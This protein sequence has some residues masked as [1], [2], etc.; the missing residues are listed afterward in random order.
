[1]EKSKKNLLATI[2]IATVF[3]IAGGIGT[4]YVFNQK[5]GQIEAL[6]LQ[7]SDL[8][9]K[10]QQ[11]DSVLNDAEGTFN[12][13]ESNLKFI[14]EKRNEIALTQNEGGKNR[15]QT[16]IDDI[17]LMNTMLEASN[18]KIAELEGRLRRSGINAKVF[19]KRIAELN[20]SI[21]NQNVEIA[22]LKKVIEEKNINLADLNTKV[23]DMNNLVVQKSDTINYKQKQIVD[24]TNE[25]NTAHFA[26]GTYKELKKEGILVKE[27]GVLG[28]GASKSI[29]GNFNNKY[30]TALDIRTTKTIPLNSKKV[31]VISEH[32]DSSYTLVKKD[33]QIAYLQI[34]NPEEFWKISK[35]AVIELK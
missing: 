29:Q 33:G 4:M 30:F 34:D 19:E 11:K 21:E 27:G 24:K 12:E 3:V 2:I 22:Q 16:V 15:K 6:T 13:I 23:Q 10:M 26:L 28:V 31:K 9:L 32:P 35:Y 5:D 17:K 14:K 20:A 18:K 1:M 8:T 7:K 25:L